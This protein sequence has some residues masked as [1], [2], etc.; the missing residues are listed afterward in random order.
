MK[1]QRKNKQD[2][3]N[4][5]KTNKAIT[6]IA[7]VVTIVVLLILAGVSISMLTGENGIIKQAIDAK[8]KTKE[9]NA[10]EQ[11]GVEVVGSYGIDGKISI[12]LL[13]EN[14]GHIEGLTHNGQSLTENPITSLPAT[15]ELDGVK[16]V[17]NGDGSTESILPIEKGKTYDKETTVTAGNDTV[18]VP[19]GA[20]ISGIE[21]ETTID[22]GLV[23]YI[24]PEGEPEITDWEADSDN[25]GI[26]DVQEKYDQFVWVPVPNAVL[27]L[28]SDT[29]ALS[30]EANIRAAVQNEIDEGRY[31]MAIKNVDGNYFG[32]LYLFSLDSTTNTVKVESDSLW[33]PLCET[34]T[35]YREPAYLTSSSNADASSSNTVGITESL[36]QTE[37]NTMVNRVSIKKGFWVGRYET[38][39]MAGTA[40]T[41]ASDALNKATVAADA[42][43]KIKVIK[44]TT[45]GISYDS[46]IP[47]FINWYR[48]YAQQKNYSNLANITAT[49]SMIWGSQWD[50]IMIWMK[51]VDNIS[52]SS[53]YVVNSIGMGNFGTISG[54]DDGWSSISAPAP[55]GYQEIYK[56]KNVYDLA[57]NVFDWTA[58]AIFDHGRFYRGGYYAETTS[59]SIPSAEGR[60]Y[61]TFP[62]GSKTH[63]GSR[64][65]LY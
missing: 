6:L 25:N 64:S 22:D 42:T 16:V 29:T 44:G 62:Y 17:I 13:N 46:S 23:I 54:V 43:N 18:T 30:T 48:M 2:I 60:C 3:R 59:Q 56:V 58:G 49:S 55:T 12:P 4:I 20:T 45:T 24:I 53:K 37:F 27:D 28:S 8:D 32:V 41:S 39:N 9:A 40:S 7:L 52:Q 34:K 36:L 14:L 65:T 63:D 31:P 1:K 35:Y 51:D 61:I 11:I 15:V 33:T 19:G 50:Q 38:S 21:E 26:I 5:I 57:G 10:K 47:N